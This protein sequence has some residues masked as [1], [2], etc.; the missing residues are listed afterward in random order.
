MSR[1]DINWRVRGLVMARSY[2][3]PDD[4]FVCSICS[5]RLFASEVVIDH[6]M[7]IKLGG[8]SEPDNLQVLCVI[9]N[10]VKGGRHPDEDFEHLIWAAHGDPEYV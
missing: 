1:P 8:G 4:C 9:C 6:I 3:A 10:S 5:G 7:P 2:F